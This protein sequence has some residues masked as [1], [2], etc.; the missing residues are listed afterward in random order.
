MRGCCLSGVTGSNLRRRRLELL[1][2]SLELLLGRL[3]RALAGVSALHGVGLRLSLVLLL[4][5]VLLLLLIHHRRLLLVHHGA[6][7][8]VHHGLWLR[9][10]HLAVLHDDGLRL[11]LSV[12]LR[13][14]KQ[15][16]D[17]S[18]EMGTRARPSTDP[19]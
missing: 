1:R 4:R 10:R 13:T 8:S 2:L 16:G 5:G 17:R 12:H 18:E 9:V 19:G 15:R 14:H 6:R 7:L 11:S 3:L